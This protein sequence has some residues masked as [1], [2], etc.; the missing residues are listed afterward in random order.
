MAKETEVHSSLSFDKKNMPVT[1][2]EVYSFRESSKIKSVVEG[3]ELSF[4]NR[5]LSFQ[6][7]QAKIKAGDIMGVDFPKG[8]D[9]ADLAIAV[10]QKNVKVQKSYGENSWRTIDAEEALKKNAIAQPG[11]GKIATTQSIDVKK[12]TGI[13]ANQFYIEKTLGMLDD[14]SLPKT[15]EAS[16]VSSSKLIFN[17]FIGYAGKTYYGQAGRQAEEVEMQFF[18]MPGQVARLDNGLGVVP[19]GASGFIPPITGGVSGFDVKPEPALP[20]KSSFFEE[21]TPTF[22]P[23]VAPDVIPDVTPIYVPDETVFPIPDQPQTPIQEPT[24]QPILTPIEEPTQPF[25][26][27]PDLP[28]GLFSWPSFGFK[29]EGKGFNVPSNFRVGGVKSG[30]KTYPI[31]TGMEALGLG[32]KKRRVSKTKKR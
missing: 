11:K 3:P 10:A 26:P 16:N 6:E 25:I 24:E 2:F 30:K 21:T 1:E 9:V 8:D 7:L 4:S 29:F 17:P 28:K 14:V 19:A 23:I 12:G 31:L 5:K 18:T 32:G 20:A 15:V 27:Q 22:T 13:D